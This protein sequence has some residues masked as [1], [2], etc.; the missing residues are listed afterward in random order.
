EE[1]IKGTLE[2]GKLADMIV[3]SDDLL[4]IDPER[5]LDVVIEKTIVGGRVVFER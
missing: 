3:L 5:I 2:P 1:D 4:T